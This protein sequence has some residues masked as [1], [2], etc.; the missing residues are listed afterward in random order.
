[1]V[2]VVWFKVQQCLVPFTMFLIKGSLERTFLDICLTTFFGVRN[3]GN[4]AAMRVSF[5]WKYSKTNRDCQNAATN[6]G[7][8]FCFWDNCIW[9]GFFKFYLL[10]RE[11]LWL[12]F[13][14]LTNSSK[15]LHITKKDFFQLTYLHSDQ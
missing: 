4:K 10:S 12:A 15:I 2:K 13:N 3:F 7:I 1:M 14:V 9:I 8:N 11:L 6:W 5:F